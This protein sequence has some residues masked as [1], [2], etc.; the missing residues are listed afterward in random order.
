MVRVTPQLITPGNTLPDLDRR[1]RVRTA[2][3]VAAFA[4]TAAILANGPV[5]AAAVEPSTMA[6]GTFAPPAGLSVA[7]A[8]QSAASTQTGKV[9]GRV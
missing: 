8:T 1:A 4:L 7:T 6:F 3:V 2:A 9:S 5:G